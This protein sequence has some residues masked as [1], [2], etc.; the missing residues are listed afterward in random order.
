MIDALLWAGDVQGARPAAGGARGHQCVS[1][2]TSRDCPEQ[3]RTAP[4][5]SEPNRIC[6]ALTCGAI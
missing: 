1:H 6:S 4:N 5:D 2:K 3:P